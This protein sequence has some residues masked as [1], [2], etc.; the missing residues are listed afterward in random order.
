[1]KMLDMDYLGDG[2]YAGHDGYQI[3]LTVG[4]HNNEPL[5][6]LEPSVIDALIRYC[7]RTIGN[8]NTSEG[9]RI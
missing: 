2:V 6:A 8:E 9:E 1:M 4:D 5:I 7:A 3:W